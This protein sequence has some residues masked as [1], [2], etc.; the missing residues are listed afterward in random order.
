MD[1]S[2]DDRVGTTP[3]GDWAQDYGMNSY[4]IGIELVHVGGQGAYPAAQLE[5]LD[6]LIAYLDATYA[7]A[8]NTGPAP[9]GQIID[10]KMWRSGNSD[11]SP[12]FAN[13]LANYQQTRTYTG[14]L[15]SS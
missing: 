7:A 11:T 4:S 13:Y 14:Q 5:A 3:V 15:R 6:T 2:R 8:G 9:A 12:E 10:H 1:E